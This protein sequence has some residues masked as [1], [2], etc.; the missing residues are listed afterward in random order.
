MS[1]PVVSLEQVRQE[2]AASGMSLETTRE[3]IAALEHQHYFTQVL[4]GLGE[5]DP[6]ATRVS[7][8]G[9]ER[10][11]PQHRDTS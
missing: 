10:Y 3:S 4:H 7:T 5:V 1:Y 9:F 2:A 11:R 6:A 8:H